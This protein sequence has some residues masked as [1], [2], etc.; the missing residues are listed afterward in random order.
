MAIDANEGA[1]DSAPAEANEG[2]KDSAPA[3]AND[4]AKELLIIDSEALVRV[5]K[6]DF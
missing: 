4:G 2:A 5:Q 1:E 6:S 3:E